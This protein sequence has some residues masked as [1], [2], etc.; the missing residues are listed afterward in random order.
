MR[1]MEV[2]ELTIVVSVSVLVFGLLS[3]LFNPFLRRYKSKESKEIEADEATDEGNS[4]GQVTD[5]GSQVDIS[6]ILVVRDNISEIRRNL[7]AFLEQEYDSKHYVIV[8]IDKAEDGSR[9]L[10]KQMEQQYDNLYTTFVPQSSR[11]MSR[12][13]LAITLG[14]KAAK[15]EWILLSDIS[16]KPQSKHCLEH[17]AKQCTEESDLVLAY[18]TYDEEVGVCRRFEHL[19]RACY[20]A[21]RALRGKAFAALSPNVVFRKSRF[22]ET[23]GYDGNLKY[24]RGEY[25]FLV[26]KHAEE[27]TT[28]LATSQEA[29]ILMDKPSK[30]EWI[31]KQL[32]YLETRKHLVGRHSF[33]ALCNLD[34]F[35]LH[36]NYLVIILSGAAAI[37]QMNYIVLASAALSLIVTVLLRCILAKRASRHFGEK[38]AFC[39]VPFL[40]VS[41]LWRNIGRL[42]RYRFA[43][44]N[45][46]ICHKV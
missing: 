11:Y 41:L 39:A 28:V 40:E 32:F 17:L 6:T 18:G 7:P 9:D 33:A 36:I 5:S 12:L 38:I 20:N 23:K 15:S 19:R 24:L 21:R 34:T 30:K 14:V 1:I 35:A 25:D 27:G 44:K 4:C 8:V 16:A 29:S 3:C 43:D 37:W 10:L 26:N 45:D 46:F 31:N 13:K 42:T 2:D 22:M